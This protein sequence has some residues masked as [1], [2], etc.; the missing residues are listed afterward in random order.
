MLLWGSVEGLPL[1]FSL[2]TTKQ[3]SWGYPWFLPPLST[4]LESGRQVGSR[5]LITTSD[6]SVF[7]IHVI[8]GPT[9]AHRRVTAVAVSLGERGQD[10][11][12]NTGSRIII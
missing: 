10:K 11:R 5:I 6:V 3:S 7:N 2:L 12:S 8:A 9:A 4:N 1:V